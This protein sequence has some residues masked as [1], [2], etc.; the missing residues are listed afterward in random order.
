[1]GLYLYMS[2]G[3]VPL[4]PKAS[5][6]HT[7]THTHTH[8]DFINIFFWESFSINSYNFEHV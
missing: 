6:P 2:R 3:A 1:M 5:S 4:G 7:H 8:V